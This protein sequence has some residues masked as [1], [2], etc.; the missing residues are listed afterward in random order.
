[1]EKPDIARGNIAFSGQATIH[2]GGGTPSTP[3]PPVL[4]FEADNVDNPGV[5]IATQFVPF[6][7]VVTATID[8]LP[9]P[10]YAGSVDFLDEPNFPGHLPINL[11]VD[12]VTGDPA[13]AWTSGVSTQSIQWI[14]PEVGDFN[15]TLD[16]GTTT[17]VVP[18]QV[19]L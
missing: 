15:V 6:N 18:V 9:D 3:S 16:D 17:V 7:V 4:S 10:A 8:G 12:G 13:T 5:M 11:Q 14:F 19:V 2:R 1:M